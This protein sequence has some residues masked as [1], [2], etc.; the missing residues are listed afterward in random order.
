MDNLIIISDLTH[1]PTEQLAFRTV[2]MFAHSYYKLEVLLEL[3]NSLKDNYY[4]FLKPRGLMDY[5]EQFITPAEHEIGIRLDTEHN[6][7][8]T[9]ITKNIRFENQ[10]NLLG[11]IKNLLSI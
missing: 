10:L 2:C 7:P 4:Y 1:P 6:Y 9:I 11:Q 8:F 3:E 5:I